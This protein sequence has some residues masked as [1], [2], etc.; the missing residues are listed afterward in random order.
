M[1]TNPKGP[2]LASAVRNISISAISVTNLARNI[3]ISARGV[4]KLSWK[5]KKILVA[6]EIEQILLQ[7]KGAEK[8]KR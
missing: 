7:R 1:N 4:T 5:S 3:S 8:R 6:K 2:V